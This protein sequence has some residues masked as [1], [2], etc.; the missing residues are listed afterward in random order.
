MKKL[1]TT[2]SSYSS[3]FTDTFANFELSEFH[4]RLNEIFQRAF[5]SVTEVILSYD[6]VRI[7]FALT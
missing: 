5:Y 3:Q 1:K 7:R 2:G 4:D 6:Q